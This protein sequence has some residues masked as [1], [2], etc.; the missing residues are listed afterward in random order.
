MLN[1]QLS[2]SPVE[3]V[4][5]QPTNISP[6]GGIVL[7][8]GS[9]GGSAKW[10]DVIAVLLAANGFFTMPKPYNKADALLTRPDI[11]NI[12][13]EG[14]ENALLYMRKL[15][16]SYHKKIGLLG[17]SRGAEQAL[18]ISQ[19]LAEENSPALPDALAVHASTSKIKPAFILKNYQPGIQQLLNKLNWLIA[20]K[21]L[22]PAWCWRN[23]HKRTFP[24][25][26][27]EIE[28]YPNPVLITHGIEDNIWKVKESKILEMRRRDKKL[29]TETYYFEEEGHSLSISARN[30]WLKI[31]SDFFVRNL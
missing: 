27:I 20:R 23:S 17:V 12:P 18:L 19:L 24:N 9:E 10:I 8:H 13:L 4:I 3:A 28:Q 31:L 6:K 16:S 21:K 11:K 15:M 26:D 30:L 1:I 29:P 25:T 14:T 5:Y 7:L 22:Q 2:S